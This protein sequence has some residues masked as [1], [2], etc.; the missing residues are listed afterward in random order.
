MHEL[1]KPP[2]PVAGMTVSAPWFIDDIDWKCEASLISCE[3]F[4]KRSW[5]FHFLLHT[6]AER[7][8]AYYKIQEYTELKDTHT[9][10]HTHTHARARAHA[11]THTSSKTSSQYV[12]LWSLAGDICR[13][14]RITSFSKKLFGF[15]KENSKFLRG[16]SAKAVNGVKDRPREKS[17]PD[18]YD[19]KTQ[20]RLYCLQG[21]LVPG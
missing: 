18:K 11:H 7:K 19:I 3:S 20:G 12:W 2:L 1:W 6:I 17:L 21:S 16:T 4:I 13:Q 5:E 15:S 8:L 10:T 9:H 14:D